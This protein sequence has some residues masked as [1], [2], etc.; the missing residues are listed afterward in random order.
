[1]RKM[2]PVVLITKIIGVTFAV[3]GRLAVGK[4]GPLA[5][6]GAVVG[7]LVLYIPGPQFEF[8]RNDKSKHRKEIQKEGKM[9]TNQNEN[10]K[11]HS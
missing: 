10:K 3:C 7:A 8:L 1:M 6:I 11:L 4:E 9:Q 2:Q 5:H